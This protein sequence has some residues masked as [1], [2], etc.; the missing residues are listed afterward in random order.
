MRHFPPLARRGREAAAADR[1]AMNPEARVGCNYRRCRSRRRRLGGGVRVLGVRGGRGAGEEAARLAV[2]RV[3]VQGRRADANGFLLSWDV[4]V[5]IEASRGR[6]R[7]IQGILSMGDVK[8]DG[9][10]GRPYS[11]GKLAVCRLE[12]VGQSRCF[13]DCQPCQLADTSQ[14]QTHGPCYTWTWARRAASLRG[15]ESLQNRQ[16]S[17]PIACG[18]TAHD[19]RACGSFS[20]CQTRSRAGRPTC[21]CC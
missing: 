4:E 6:E 7:A 1:C 12:I 9:C 2:G 11:A 20:P 21:R 17:R 19:Q 13:T 8:E 3:L 10:S 14:A 18:A 15:G 16:M 5:R